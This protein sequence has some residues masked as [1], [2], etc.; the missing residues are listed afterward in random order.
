MKS[1]TLRLALL[2]ALAL[3]AFGCTGKR[4][5]IVNTDMVYKE[6]VASEKG[7]DYLRSISA[8]MQKT[9]EAAAAKVENAKGKKGKEAAQAEMQAALVE[10]QQ[11]LNAEQQQ[12]V[13]A[14]TD[15]Y[16]TAMENCRVKGKFDVII[17]SEAALAHDPQID[18]TKQVLDEMNAMPIEFTPIKPEAPADQPADQPAQ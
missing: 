11:R 15:A 12:V 18:I 5:A 7:T 9:Y 16:K 1:F 13:T 3:V 6:S 17:P 8:D 10:M 14:L 2:A 4:V